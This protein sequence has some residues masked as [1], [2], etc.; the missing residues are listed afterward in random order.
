VL[1]RLLCRGVVVGQSEGGL[2]LGLGTLF[3]A[4]TFE[5]AAE[6]HIG[7]EGGGCVGLC[8]RGEIA[9][10]NVLG[11]VCFSV[12]LCENAG[13]IDEGRAVGAIDVDG[14]MEGFYGL[15]LLVATEV[16]VA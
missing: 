12:K 10:K 11:Y 13:D 6:F 8:V 14:M 4:I 3:V 5:K 15:I 16:E 9:A 7:L 1:Y 2:K